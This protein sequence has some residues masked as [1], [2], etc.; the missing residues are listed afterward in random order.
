MFPY[1][2]Q[3]SPL[4]AKSA[5]AG[6]AASLRPAPDTGAPGVEQPVTPALTAGPESYRFSR[7]T[8]WITTCPPPLIGPPGVQRN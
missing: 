3:G 4:S 7:T 8:D 6:A 5:G 1:V 2:P